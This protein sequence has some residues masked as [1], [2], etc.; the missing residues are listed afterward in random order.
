MLLKLL[1]VNSLTILRIIGSSLLIP[2]YFKYSILIVGIVSLTCYFTDILD[3]ILA[4][5]WHVS[6]FLGALLDGIA[7]KIL[8]VVNFIIL[9]LIT[10]YAL[11]PIIFECLIVIIQLFKFN[12]HYNIKSNIFGKIKMWVLA[13]CIALIYFINYKISNFNNY[14]LILLPVIIMECLTIISYFLEIFKT[15]EIKTK[16]MV[17]SEILVKSKNTKEHIKDIWINP[18]F[19]DNHKNDS[20]LKDLRKLTRE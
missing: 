5:Y 15:Q 16:E 3:G 18:E 17:N 13:L 14:F 6:T 10:P 1:L 20:N 19:Y 12:K 7:D 8:T 2:I 9:Y 11:V 4:R